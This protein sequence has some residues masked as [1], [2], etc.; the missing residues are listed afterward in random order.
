[1]LKFLSRRKRSRKALLWAFILLLALGLI[2]VFT[3]GPGGLQGVASD[4]TAVAEVGDYEV[5]LKELRTTLSSYGQ[6]LSQGQPG[7]QMNDLGFLY[8]IYGKQVL[9]G[10]IRQKVVLY[11]ADRL[12]LKTTDQEVQERLRQI[13]NPW[14]GADAYRAQLRQSGMTPVQFEDSIRASIAEQKLRSYITAATRVS[15]QEVEEDY[16]RSNTSYMVRWVDVSADTFRDKVQFTDADLRAFFDARRSE[17]RIDTEQRRARYIF[18]D[19]NKAGETIQVS[20][21]ELRAEFNPERGVRQVRVSQ[22]VLNIPKEPPK[23]TDA[24]NP[25]DQSAAPPATTPEEETR[26]KAEELIARAKGEGGKPA[27]DFAALARQYSEDAKS[28]AAGGDIGWVNKDDKRESDD[29]LNRVFSMQKDEVSQPIR[30]GDQFYILKITDRKLPTFEESRE[31]LLKEARARKGYTK[32]VE[33]ASEAAQRFKESK[34]AEAVAAELNSKHGAEVAVVRQT[35]FFAEGDSLPDLGAAAEF[36]SAVFDLENP[37][38]ITEYLSVN[39]G[40]AVAQYTEKRDPH[41]AE[42]EEVRSKV[43]DRY[44]TEKAREMA[45]EKARQLAGSASPDA[46]KSAADAAGLKTDERAG[47]SGNDSI[48]PLVSEANRRA[49]YNL[50][51]GEVT[52]E[53]VK[54]ES[55]DSYVVAAL[56]SRKDADMGEPFQ[57]ERK[58]IEERLL[59]S[60]RSTL[61]SAYMAQAQERLKREGEIKIYQDTIDSALASTSAVPGA[62]PQSTGFPSTPGRT[63]P[64]R[65]PQGTRTA[66]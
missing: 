27:E 43:E 64:R 7:M 52:R 16:R 11:E 19:Q 49:V 29:P 21:D 58:S 46:L 24:Q 23:R 20:D 31:Q 37:G 10:L 66:Q 35:P 62:S 61:F 40:F 54:V 60:K 17:F 33:I 12:N 2:V 59:D 36:Q 9:D 57:K 14:P 15:P 42:F 22:I 38:D 32:A 34:N 1:M 26:K 4:D 48:G 39:N 45:A 13:F 6:Q 18:I 63:S 41:D 65:R 25:A 3:P 50:N 28:R 51:P 56:I 55:S 47:L 53:P 44:R 8:S 30:K 5:T